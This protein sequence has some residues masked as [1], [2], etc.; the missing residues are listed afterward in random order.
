M[1]NM[2]RM[3]TIRDRLSMVLMMNDCDRLINR[4]L[5]MVAIPDAAMM[6]K[7]AKCG[8]PDHEGRKCTICKARREGIEAYLFELLAQ[9]TPE[10]RENRW[11]F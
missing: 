3:N 4:I 2:I 11:S 8:D 9:R 1:M 7:A 10:S 5:G 6:R